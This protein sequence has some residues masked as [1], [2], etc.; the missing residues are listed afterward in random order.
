[1]L[2]AYVFFIAGAVLSGPAGDP[3]QPSGPN[4]LVML[5]GRAPPTAPCASGSPGCANPSP[6]TPGVGPNASGVVTPP[7]ARR[8]SPTQ[9]QAAA[10]G[11]G[12]RLREGGGYDYRG[13][14]GERFSAF[15]RPDGSVVFDID[16][17]IQ[18]K[19]IGVCAVA[20]CVQSKK[21]SLGVNAVIGGALVAASIAAAIVGGASDSDNQNQL[22]ESPTVTHPRTAP[23]SS[24]V[25][26]FSPAAVVGVSGRYGYLPSPVAAMTGFLE[27][28]FEFRLQLAFEIYLERLD[29]QGRRLPG[30][31]LSAWSNPE[32]PSEDRRASLLQIWDD[33]QAPPPEHPDGVLAAALQTDVE[34][35]RQRAATEARQMILDFV[36]RHVRRGSA[37]AFTEAELREYNARPST[38]VAFEPY[39]DPGS[40]PLRTP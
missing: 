14:G 26:A 30:D 3:A 25:P 33:V 2:A 37:V 19:G 6:T 10:L 22:N 4:A 35:H 39:R 9:Q 32:F 21:P 24:T 8:Q 16:P 11:L 5:P 18:V 38:E 15:I 23:L 27:R 12:L 29:E 36:R 31:L 13:M 7:L 20:V 17:L 34:P 28:T 40:T 1:M